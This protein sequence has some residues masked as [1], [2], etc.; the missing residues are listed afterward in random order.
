MIKHIVGI[1]LFT[2]IVGTSA[3]IACLFGVV[4]ERT[5]SVSEHKSYRVYKDKKRKKRCRKKRK[6]RRHHEE[7]VVFGH[8]DSSQY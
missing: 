1:V 5:N 6:R 4:T 7:T 8:S 2:F 3:A